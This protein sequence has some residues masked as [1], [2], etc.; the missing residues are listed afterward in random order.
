MKTIAILLFTIIINSCCTANKTTNLS[1]ANTNSNAKTDIEESKITQENV[2]IE[3]SA[4]ARGNFKKI[5]LDHKTVSVQQGF[6]VEPTV[7]PCSDEDW[8]SMMKLVSGFNLKSMR[9]LEAPSQAHRYDG[10]PITSFTITKDGNTHEVPSFDAGNPHK[11]IAPL[12]EMVLNI[13][14]KSKE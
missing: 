5:I 10:A 3:Y 8:N 12:V 6:D 9:T 4:H 11:D 13:A 2:K 7:K 14:E 1:A